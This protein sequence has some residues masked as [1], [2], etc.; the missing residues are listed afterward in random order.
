MGTMILFHIAGECGGDWLLTRN[1]THWAFTTDPAGD[2]ACTVTIPQ[3]LAWSLF[4]K[5]LDRDLARTQIE[6]EGNRAMADG[7]LQL[8]AIVG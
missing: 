1:A 4:T 3:A 8:A 2:I 6:I 5:G 7:V